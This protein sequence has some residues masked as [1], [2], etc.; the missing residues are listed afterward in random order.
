M[1]D[2]REYMLRKAAEFK[3]ELADERDYFFLVFF[4]DEDG[5]HVGAVSSMSDDDIK[6]M[7]FE[8]I[9]KAGEPESVPYAEN[10]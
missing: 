6:R 9:A 10:P 7:M 5:V 4:N 8:F 2:K 1:K 3:Q